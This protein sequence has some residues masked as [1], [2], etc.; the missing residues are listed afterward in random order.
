[1]AHTNNRPLKDHSAKATR[2]AGSSLRTTTIVL[3]DNWR[4]CPRWN[5]RF[6]SMRTTYTWKSL[7][8]SHPSCE[9][10]LHEPLLAILPCKTRLSVWKSHSSIPYHYHFDSQILAVNNVE[11][12]TLRAIGTSCENRWV[13]LFSRSR[14]IVSNTAAPGCWCHASHTSCGTI[15]AW[16]NTFSITIVHT[17]CIASLI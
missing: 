17:P 5:H 10:H 6:I 12:I 11:P 8:K 1:M 7:T 2:K 13:T 4:T 14:I 16:R 9:K 3:Q 15:M